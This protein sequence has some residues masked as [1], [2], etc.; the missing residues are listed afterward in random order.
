[1]PVIITFLA[2]HQEYAF[3]IHAGKYTKLKI[4][5]WIP[6]NFIFAIISLSVNLL[7]DH[8]GRD[9]EPYMSTQIWLHCKFI[10]YEHLCSSKQIGY[11]F[12]INAVLLSLAI[13]ENTRGLHERGWVSCSRFGEIHTLY[14]LDMMSSF[15]MSLKV[16]FLSEGIVTIWTRKWLFSAVLL[17]VHLQQNNDKITGVNVPCCTIL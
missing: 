16:A 10:S 3:F 15:Y 14:H 4:P 6:C 5:F 8:T 17:Q 7:Q 13:A 11:I 2:M 1:M 9:S 12:Q